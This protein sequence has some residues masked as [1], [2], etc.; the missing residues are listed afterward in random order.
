MLG[1]REIDFLLKRR[2]PRDTGRGAWRKQ[3]GKKKKMKMHYD[4]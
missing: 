1:N 4:H 3:G 2:G